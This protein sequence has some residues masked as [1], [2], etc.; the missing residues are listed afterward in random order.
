VADVGATLQQGQVTLSPADYAGY[1]AD[2]S[3]SDGAEFLKLPEVLE[4]LFKGPEQS[5]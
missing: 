3:P 5:S 1:G 2:G 4:N